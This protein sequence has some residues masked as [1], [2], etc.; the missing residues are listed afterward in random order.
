MG[1]RIRNACGNLVDRIRFGYVVDFLYVK[2]FAVSNV[3]DVCVTSGVIL[4]AYYLIFRLPA[5]TPQDATPATPAVPPPPVDDSAKSE[6][7]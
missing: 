7:P 1:S 3:A 5:T 2:Y 6:T 4:L